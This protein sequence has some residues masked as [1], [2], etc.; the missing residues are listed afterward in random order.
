MGQAYPSAAHIERIAPSP[1]GRLHLGHAFSALTAYE[2]AQNAGG[3]CLLRIEDIDIG[4]SRREF[5]DG[6]YEDL[7]WLG[8]QWPEPVLRQSGNFPAYRSA[9]DRL[10]AMGLTYPCSCTRR[11]IVS[12]MDDPQEGGPDGPVYPGTC[13]VGADE[14]KPCV[15]RL[16]MAEAVAQAPALSFVEIGSGPNG[17]HGEIAVD[18]EWLIKKAG[19]IVLARKDAPTSYHLS[20]VV[21][22]AAQGV[23]HVTR[24]EDLFPATPIHR[25]LQALLD[26]PTP[27]YRHHRL[28]RDE[29]GKRLAK[30]H[31]SAAL[32][33]LR[34]QGWTVSDVREAV[35]LV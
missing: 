25:L 18:P 22:D 9:L 2:A 32:A 3:V 16:K 21:D 34:A 24:G 4:R 15:I 12:A 30:R 1:T 10:T 8:V 26:L 33:T 29:D 13:R 31:D 19:D 14:A 20:V 17:E 27:I 11:D 23:T 7:R 6:I 5:E 28:I 35:G